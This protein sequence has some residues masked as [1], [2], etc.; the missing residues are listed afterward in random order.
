[1]WIRKETCDEKVLFSYADFD[2][3]EL[4]KHL[5]Q[6]KEISSYMPWLEKVK[7]IAQ[8]I[9]LVNKYDKIILKPIG[10]FSK[11]PSF[12]LRAKNKVFELIENTKKDRVYETFNDKNTLEEFLISKK[13]FFGQYLIQREMEFITFGERPYELYIIMRRERKTWIYDKVEC[14]IWDNSFLISKPDYHVKDKILK[15]FVKKSLPVGLNYENFV[16][17]VK[18]LCSSTCKS[19]EKFHHSVCNLEII[20]GIDK[21]K[22]IWITDINIPDKK[23][24]IRYLD[25][26][27]YYSKKCSYIIYKTCQDT[28][29]NN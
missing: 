11:R 19:I 22:R 15:R 13:I 17:E 5:R 6:Y 25:Y 9:E 4:Y 1:M 3:Y 7:D 20:I 16:A 24:I 28:I 23:K 21:N 26:E 29:V 8:V 2:K 14:C 12:R 18:A 27:V 10:F